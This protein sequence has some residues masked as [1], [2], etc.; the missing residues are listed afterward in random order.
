M[1]AN[2]DVVRSILANWERGDLSSVDWAE[3]DID[4]VFADGPEPGTHVGRA[5]MQELFR[6]WLNSFASFR[7]LADRVIEVDSHQVLALTHAGGHGKTSGVDLAEAGSA[8]A[9][10]FELRDG[11]VARLVVYFNRHHALTEL[12]LE[13]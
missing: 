5:A 13:A 10:L 7:L 4:F 11:K 2:L 9:H 1:T 8:F 12:G 6:S 3:R